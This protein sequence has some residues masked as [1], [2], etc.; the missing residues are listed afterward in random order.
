MSIVEI[1]SR[2]FHLQN[3]TQEM[4]S[5]VF[6]IYEVLNSY[7]IMKYIKYSWSCINYG[8]DN[9]ILVFKNLRQNILANR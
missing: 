4:F 7:W 3:V 8:P 9:K 2:M 5:N 6:C 1:N